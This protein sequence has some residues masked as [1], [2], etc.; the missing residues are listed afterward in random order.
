M[1]LPFH[2][3]L[4]GREHVTIVATRGEDHYVGVAEVR[5]QL[6]EGEWRVRQRRAAPL[7]VQQSRQFDR[8]ERAAGADCDE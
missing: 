7:L 6:D 4:I 2:S 1:G 5:L 3:G 8:G